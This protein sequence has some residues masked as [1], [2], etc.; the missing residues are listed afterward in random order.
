VYMQPMY[1]KKI[2]FGKKGFPFQ[3]GYYG[4]DQNYSLGI[5]PVSERMWVEELFYFPGH[6][7]VPT[8]KEIRQ[9]TEAA[10]K[11]LQ[12]KEEIKAWANI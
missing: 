10:E 4:K 7:F 1:Q 12:Y 11:V 9:F 8:D 3:A 6:S 5:C 2:A